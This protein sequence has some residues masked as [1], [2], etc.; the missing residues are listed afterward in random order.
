VFALAL[1]E[2]TRDLVR[3]FVFQHPLKYGAARCGIS[4]KPSWDAHLPTGDAHS[5]ISRSDQMYQIKINT[6]PFC[7]LYT[8][9]DVLAT[10]K[11]ENPLNVEVFKNGEAMQVVRNSY[12]RYGIQ[13]LGDITEL[14]TAMLTEVDINHIR[15]FGVVRQPYEMLPESWHAFIAIGSAA[16]NVSPCFTE[17]QRRQKCEYLD[18]QGH[19]TTGSIEYFMNSLMVAKFDY[20]H[21]GPA[22]DRDGQTNG[23][24]EVHV[25][26]AL[27]YGKNVPLEVI[28]WYKANPEEVKSIGSWFALLL[29]RPEY[30][31][32]M[33]PHKLKNLVNLCSGDNIELTNENAPYFIGLMAELPDS[34]TCSQIDDF[35]YAKGILKLRRSTLQLVP[36]D[37]S[38]A[39]SPFALTLRAMLGEKRKTNAIE[40]ANEQRSKYHHSL[41]QLH[42]SI[43]EA[44]QLPGRETLCY[45]NQLAEAIDTK[46]VGV[47]LT[48]LDTSYEHNQTT[49]KA[50][51]ETFG[52]KVNGL[53]AAERRDVIFA[54]CGYDSEMRAK[55]EKEVDDKQAK[56]NYEREAKSAR[57]TAESCKTR[58]NG[59][60]MT[61][62][63]YVDRAVAEGFTVIST[64]KKGAATQ[65]WLSNVDKGHSRSI[66]K[67]NGSL[68][69]A[70][71]V[72]GVTEYR[73][74]A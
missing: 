71:L 20:G 24:H 46:N 1:I 38:L 73:R 74:A 53:K 16:Y 63:E 26:Y 29:E 4:N 19:T 23:R 15:P 27:A 56:S 41:R 68:D 47:M 54:F 44:N 36:C 5:A 60:I 65:Y 48:Y 18:Y 25:A 3:S 39:Y 35:L 61:V 14:M 57:S 30:R 2:R 50:V 33:S 8:L 37:L 13:Q 45:S 31:G 22:Y 40:H 69:Y 28:E 11:Q 58:F 6:L 66:H 21:N 59:E 32:T 9:A 43:A 49:K 10:L 51:Y 72:H 52:L 55:Y 62:A 67:K 42:E 34:I 7:N 70:K 64:T 12:G 17:E